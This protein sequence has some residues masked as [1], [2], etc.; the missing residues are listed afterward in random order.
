VFIEAEEI[1][2]ETFVQSGNVLFEAPSATAGRIVVNVAEG[3]GREFGFATPG[4]CAVPR[5]GR[6]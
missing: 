5:R 2:V 6:R 1:G 4:F 3:I